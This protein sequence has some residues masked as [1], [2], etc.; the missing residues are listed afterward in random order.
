[1]HWL[2]VRI[3]ARYQTRQSNLQNFTFDATAYGIEFQARLPKPR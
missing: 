3:Y 2:A 1:L